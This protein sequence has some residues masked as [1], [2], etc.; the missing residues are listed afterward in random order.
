M[1]YAKITSIYYQT[2][3]K[4]DATWKTDAKNLSVRSYQGL[5]LIFLDERVDFAN[6]NKSE[7]FFNPAIKKV[8]I[9]TNGIP[10]Q[11]FAH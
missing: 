6:N 11:L 7:E 10:H 4:K 1:F 2:L 5:L 8:L 3:S 9:I